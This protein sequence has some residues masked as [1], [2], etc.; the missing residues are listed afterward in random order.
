[1]FLSRRKMGPSLSDGA[2]LGFVRHFQVRFPGLL[3]AFQCNIYFLRCATMRKQLSDILFLVQ[4][5]LIMKKTP[6]SRCRR[7][8]LQSVLRRNLL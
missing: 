6:D 1:V 4:G 5:N 3:G 7:E 2:C 8:F